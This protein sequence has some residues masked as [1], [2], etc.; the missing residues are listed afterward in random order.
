MIGGHF[1]IKDEM[2]NMRLFKVGLLYGTM[3]EVS[4]RYKF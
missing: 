1:T 4:V 2:L 3:P